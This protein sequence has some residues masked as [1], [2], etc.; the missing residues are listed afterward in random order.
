MIAIRTLPRHPDTSATR[1]RLTAMIAAYALLAQ[2]LLGA[3]AAAYG[4]A[5][6]AADASVLA[7]LAELCTPDGLVRVSYPEADTG[8]PAAP[9]PVTPKCPFYLTGGQGAVLAP[10][11]D[12]VHEPPVASV[13]ADWQPAGCPIRSPLYV[14]EIH[15]RGP[16]VAA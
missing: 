4:P 15:P 2:I 12:W 1:R 13:A 14:T 8:D 7:Q 6:A 11:R 3:L 10:N 5:Q 16:P 9:P